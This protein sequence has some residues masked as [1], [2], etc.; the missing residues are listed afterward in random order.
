MIRLP[1]NRVS[2]TRFSIN[3][4]LKKKKKKKKK[5][6]YDYFIPSSSLQMNRRDNL[7]QWRNVFVVVVVC[8]MSRFISFANF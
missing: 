8:Q 7:C 6:T 3:V 2:T 5:K 1:N 4:L